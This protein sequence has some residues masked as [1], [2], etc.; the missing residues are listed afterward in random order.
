MMVTVGA[1]VST[2]Q[3]KLVLP[4]VELD[5]VVVTSAS[6]A[7]TVNECWPGDSAAYVTV[8]VGLTPDAGRDGVQS[9]G[10]APSMLQARVR[11]GGREPGGSWGRRMSSSSDAVM[12]KA[13]VALLVGS[14]GWAVTV[15]TGVVVSGGQLSVSTR[16]ETGG[17]MFRAGVSTKV[18]LE[19]GSWQPAFPARTL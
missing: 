16:P 19:F 13:A 12:L 11:P 18:W 9:V 1:V 8:A 5:W 4:V 10:A 6:V 14:A 15:T 17:G 7:L 3:V 2:R